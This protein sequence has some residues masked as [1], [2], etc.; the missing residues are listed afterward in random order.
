MTRPAPTGGVVATAAGT[1]G[2]DDNNSKLSINDCDGGRA[3]HGHR[4]DEV[5]RHPRGRERAYGQRQL[6]DGEW[7]HCSRGV[8]Y[9]A[10]SG[11]V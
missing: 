6:G 3:E 11:A 10:G 7:R 2:N 9:T 8:D 5:H 4:D 1:I